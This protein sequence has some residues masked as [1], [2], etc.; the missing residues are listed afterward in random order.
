MCWPGHPSTLE[1]GRAPHCCLQDAPRFCSGTLCDPELVAYIN[2]AFLCWGGDLRC[3]DAFRLSSSLGAVAYPY[4]GLL[5]FSGA[6]WARTSCLPC[7]A[8][9]HA[10]V[11]AWLGCGTPP[12][13]LHTATE[14]MLAS[15]R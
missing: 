1:R 9:A 7:L 4:V 2:N 5:A 14:P 6:R 15:F 10:L 11:L 12:P 3:S 8:L 13:P